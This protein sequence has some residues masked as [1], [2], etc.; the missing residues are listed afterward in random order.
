MSF[1]NSK[2]KELKGMKKKNSLAFIIGII[3]GVF[4]LNG[5][6]IWL[7]IPTYDQLLRMI[8]GEPNLLNGIISLIIS[9]VLIYLIVG[10]VPQL[11]KV[12]F[13]KRG[14]NK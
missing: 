2:I 14:F 1:L 6:L 7:G 9:G 11:K 13:K 10:G 4:F 12:L 8:L 5:I 3:F